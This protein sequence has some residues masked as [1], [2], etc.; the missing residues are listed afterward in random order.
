[1]KISFALHT[2]GTWNKWLRSGALVL[3]VLMVFVVTASYPLIYK[4]YT[5]YTNH[6]SAK[7][8]LY[9]TASEYGFGV[10]EAE[11][12][13]FRSLLNIPGRLLRQIDVPTIVLDVKFKNMAKLQAKRAEAISIGILVQESDDEVP[14][15]IRYGDQTLRAKIRLKGDWVDHL[16]GDK[17]SLRV[18]L[19]DDGHV[20]GMRR[21]SLQHPAARGYQAEALFMETLRSFGVLAPR[22]L[23]VNLILNGQNLGIMAI[24]E[25]FSKELLE[26]QGRREGV[27]I[28]LDESLVWAHNFD[29]LRGFQG[30]FDDFQNAK[31]NAFQ[32][33][34]IAESE[35]LSRNLRTATGLMRGFAERRLTASDVFDP[36]L[37]GRFLAVAD[38]WGAWHSLDWI[39][40]RFYLNPIS[41]RLEPIG[42]DAELQIRR[43][44]GRSTTD[45]PITIAL[46]E[47]RRVFDAYKRTASRLVDHFRNENVIQALDKLEQEHLQI[48]QTEF[49]LL[50]GFDR[51]ELAGKARDIFGEIENIIQLNYA[52][53][54]ADFVNRKTDPIT[55]PQLAHAFIIG[56]VSGL[57]TLE[58]TS[59]VPMRSTCNR[60]I[61]R[62]RMVILRT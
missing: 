42:F 2:G 45:S 59:A 62:G 17:I 61:G 20:F 19:R 30:P 13:Y 55:Y 15:S 36:E 25:H 8:A 54:M 31:V 53:F 49:V 35:D 34:K 41:L 52:T 6:L 1:M 37:M 16:Q 5:H 14:A 18:Q 57:D 48:L 46:M 40:M 43:R 10:F 51:A 3:I 50:E 32:M 24:E 26:S 47:D 27:I 7:A 23:F 38:F 39:N 28:R 58:L 11:P 33:S 12:S 29:A 22:F 60:S 21:F 4:F 9:V 56:G 44:E